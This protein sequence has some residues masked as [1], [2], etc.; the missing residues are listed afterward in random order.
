MA[1]PPTVVVELYDS[2][3]Y[4]SVFI[5][6]NQ[7]LT[8][9]PVCKGCVLNIQGADEFM[10]RCV[11]QPSL[12]ASPSLAWFPIRRGDRSAGELLAA[13]ELIRREKVGRKNFIM[14]LSSVC[15]PPVFLSFKDDKFVLRRLH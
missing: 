10:G 8:I 9:V 7:D 12:T 3:T 1:T 11:C 4:V 2:D 5:N 14:T 15:L 13:F 6:V